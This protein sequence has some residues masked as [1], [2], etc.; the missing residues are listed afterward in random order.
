[1]VRAAERSKD[2]RA[3][4]TIAPVLRDN[5]IELGVPPEKVHI[6]ADAVDLDL[7]NRPAGYVKESRDRP[8][9]VYAGHLYDYK[10]IPTILEAARLLPKYDFALVGGHAADVERVSD[11]VKSNRLTNVALTGLLPLSAV[12]EHLWESDVLLL[13]P[14]AN[15]PSAQWTSP[16]KLGEYLASGNPVVATRIPALEYWLRNDEVLFVPPDDGNALAS[17]IRHLLEN[18]KHAVEI[19]NR[20]SRFALNL[21]YRKRCKKIIELAKA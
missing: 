14:S 20:G 10:G 1:M 19:A 13:P 2:F 12:P 8:K 18:I 11:H 9:I 21:S 17:G 16:V 6:L 15:H 7:F 5:F 4:V 3:L